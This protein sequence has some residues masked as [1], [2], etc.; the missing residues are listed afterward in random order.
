MRKIA[1]WLLITVFIFACNNST[2]TKSTTTDTTKKDTSVVKDSTNPNA[3]A[4]TNAQY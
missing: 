1:I 4:A 3:P 2:E